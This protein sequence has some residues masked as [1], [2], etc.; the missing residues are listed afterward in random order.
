[1]DQAD[2]MKKYGGFIPGIRPGKR[3]AE[4]IDKILTRL[5]F[6]GAVY[7]GAVSL[8][9]TFLISGIRV[10]MLPWIGPFLE[11]VV[12]AFVTSGLGLK[13][14]F[15]GTSLLIVVSVTM[16]TIT[17]VQSHMLAHQYEGLI[18]KSKLRGKG[19][20]RKARQ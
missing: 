20:K 12:P 6:A 16:D 2:N 11:K 4:Y 14:V 7:L 3:T 5:T 18:E 9:P 8:L 15:G 1:M 10:Q 13:F 17:Q 19:R